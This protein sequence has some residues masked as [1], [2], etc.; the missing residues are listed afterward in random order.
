MSGEAAMF[1]AQ[2]VGTQQFRVGMNSPYAAHNFQLLL[3]IIH[4]LD[5]R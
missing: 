2:L 4:W 3:N 5:R 1:S